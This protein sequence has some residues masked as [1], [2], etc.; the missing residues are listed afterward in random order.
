M[1]RS[2]DATPVGGTDTTAWPWWQ[3]GQLVASHLPAGTIRVRAPQSA[4]QI[5]AGGEQVLPRDSEEA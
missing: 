4:V 5:T 1:K 3:A 2:D